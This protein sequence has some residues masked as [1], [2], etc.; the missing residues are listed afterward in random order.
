MPTFIVNK[1]KM[2]VYKEKGRKRYGVFLFEEPNV[3]YKVGSFHN[4]EAAW[5]FIDY[6][7]KMFEEVR[8]E[9]E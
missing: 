1:K 5:H 2:T 4:D 9:N 7:N 3:W 8:K 6:L